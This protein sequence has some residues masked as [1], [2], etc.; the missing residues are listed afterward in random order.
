[1]CLKVKKKGEG[2]G[3]TRCVKNFPPTQSFWDTS[4]LL[5]LPLYNWHSLSLLPQLSWP[6]APGQLGEEM[7]CSLSIAA[8]HIGI[9][10]STFFFFYNYHKPCRCSLCNGMMVF[11]VLNLK[12]QLF[13]LQ[14]KRGTS[15]IRKKKA[16]K[17]WGDH[18]W[19]KNRWY[20]SEFCPWPRARE[21]P[22]QTSKLGVHIK[23]AAFMASPSSWQPCPHKEFNSASDVLIIDILHFTLDVVNRG[24]SYKMQQEM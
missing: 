2:D 14:E 23:L 3:A 4:Y 19:T 24:N 5:T 17:G 11:T 9:L 12:L 21:T 22:F 7:C 8:T 20:S 16:E 1:M 15:C 10:I 18:F 6:E 13:L